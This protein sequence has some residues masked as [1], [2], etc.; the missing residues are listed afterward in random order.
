MQGSFLRRLLSPLVEL[1]PGEAPTSLLLF[2]YAFLA[3][4]SYNI[5]QPLT[6]SK[7]ISSL[8]AVN[9]PYV[10]FGASL[11]IGVLM[12]LYTRVVSRLPRRWALAIVQVAMAS[13]MVGFWVWFQREEQWASVAF[14]LW[15]LILGLLLVSQFWTLA[16][17]IYDP[18]QA[19]RLFAFIGGG[20]TLGGATGAAITRFMVERI[21]T[22]ALLLWSAAVLIACMVVV[23]LV[24][25]RER[26][27]TPPADASEVEKGVSL[28]RAGELLKSSRQIQLI[29]LV[30]AF[31]SIG[32]ALIDQQLNM[33]AEVFKGRGEQD[34]IGAFLA[35]VR[36]YLSL[37][38]FFLQVWVTPW[39]HRYL[40]IGVALLL[41]PLGLSGTA[42]TILI[43]AALW[44]PAVAS[45]LDRSIR[46]TVDKTTREVLFLPLPSH[47]RQEVKPF[48]DV[49]VDRLSRGLGSLLMLVLIQPWGL[50]L[51]WYQLSLVSLLLA[52]AWF[53]LA[54]RAKREYLESFRKSIQERNVEP[55]ELR[56][57]V[58]DLST[59]ET[60]MEELASP[61][62]RRVLYAI[63]ILESLDKRNLV[64][65]LLLF[66]ESP[67][68][69]VRVLEA[70][71]A[72]RPELAERWLP[73]IEKALGDESPEV[74]AA[75]VT[76]L[77]TIRGQ[78]VTELLRPY[79]QDRDARIATTAAVVMARSGTDEDTRSAEAV[80]GGFVADTSASGAP[81]RREVA[82]ALRQIPDRRFLPLL[83]PLLQD[84]RTEVA[85]EAM[86]AVRALG[87]CEALLMP[88]LI[89]LLRHRR[90]KSSAREVLIGY[91]DDVLDALE[92]FL[93]DPEEDL[94]V[95]RHIPATLARIPTQKSME[96]L[97]A[98][99]EDRDGF[100][101]YKTVA[102]IEKLRRDAPAL[103]PKKEP[104]EA[105]LLGESL[106]YLSYLSLRYNLFVRG[107][108][109]TKA[110][111]DRALQE[112]L[113]RTLD[114]CYRLL[115]LLYSQEDVATAR[116]AIER[117]DART[118]ASALEYLDNTLSGP[119]RKRVMLMIDDVPP[120][121]KVRRANVIVKTRVRDVEETLL[122]LINDEDQVVAAAAIAL[123]EEREL[124]V[125]TPDIEYLFEHRSVA[126]RCVF[127][128]ASWTL[129]RH[130]LSDSRRRSL[131]LEPLPVMELAAVLQRIPLFSS[132]SVDELFR[133]AALGRQVRYEAGH[134]LYREGALAV[135]AQFLLDGAASAS[136]SRDGASREIG[137][138][139]PLGLE[140]VL[141]GSALPD[142]VRALRNSVCL[143][144][145]ADELRSLVSDDSELLRGL[146][147]ML[148]SEDG[149]PTASVVRGLGVD[150]IPLSS[151]KL[152]PIERALLLERVPLF[153]GIAEAEILNLASI[154]QEISLDEEGQPIEE[155]G[156][157][158]LWIVIE[159]RLSL[160]SSLVAERGD[161]VGVRE[162][163]SG[164][165]LGRRGV[166]L[167]RGRALRIDGEDLFDLLGQRPSLLQELFAALFRAR[168]ARRTR[169]EL[170][171]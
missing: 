15:G 83:I 79:L 25:G 38:A 150:A 42:T 96:I 102:A 152:A 12:L 113:A 128:A 45:V 46:Y 162:T 80:L 112:K 20:V 95:R 10:I 147:R 159:G 138:P 77:A 158:S 86:S 75:A 31:G 48:V 101:Q 126:D 149:V 66:H 33:A 145:S 88:T 117:G 2:L 107:G 76:A 154:A 121:E 19:K 136:S 1:R 53:V 119:I 111:L 170:R 26:E 122:S 11:V 41:L 51:E 5:V 166:V 82:R 167:T 142:T 92:H 151:S 3:M 44:A 36:V 106:R 110:L 50:A 78:R 70:L 40:G 59:I 90:L 130:R 89:S 164:T 100:L 43:A 29:A 114:R 72:G 32:A 123:V 132:V 17:A 109:P 39:I 22:N 9:I 94:W 35:E 28:R 157:P 67:A 84:S 81:A 146:L 23:V 49:T 148:V 68:V 131:W 55:A 37:A 65:P 156:L 74:R 14:Y 160:D 98:T 153:Q 103:G 57:D 118:R 134:V 52:G 13:V 27:A 125:L 141:E 91:G 60:L 97:L 71:G 87:S 63:G 133:I 18:R 69:R 143:A 61:D 108:V 56:V 8:G 99:L 7:L 58:A 93:R 161:S 144:L 6:R 21:G 135:E 30:I 62:E 73:S 168:R 124:W 115:G 54:V 16:N 163:L 105:L 165:P 24:L 116:R 85:D 137:P 64:T 4:T 140:S 47:L 169:R 139:A 171:E 129:A 120:E 104:I 155:T 34:A 127:E